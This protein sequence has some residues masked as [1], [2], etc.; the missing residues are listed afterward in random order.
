MILLLPM[1]SFTAAGDARPV[2]RAWP[3]GS[4][5]CPWCDYPHRPGRTACD[6]PWCESNPAWTRERLLAHR[7]E[8]AE[9][10]ARKEREQRSRETAA[11][12][13][14]DRAREHQEWEVAQI[15][16]ARSRGACLRCLFQPG[17]ERVKF[18][19][20]RGACPKDRK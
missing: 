16:E 4:V 17:W 5:A 20:H 6:N 8:A 13:A 14:R 10:R 2:T 3:D 18:V 12:A 11:Q 7:A 15:Q 1:L 19:R 9:A